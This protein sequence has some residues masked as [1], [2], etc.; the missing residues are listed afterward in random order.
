MLSYI[1]PSSPPLDHLTKSR[2]R[3][4]IHKASKKTKS[5]EPFHVA[6]ANNAPPVKSS[7]LSPPRLKQP[8]TQNNPPRSP[9]SSVNSSV[10]SEQSPDSPTRPQ[11]SP[12]RLTAPED[13]VDI[14]NDWTLVYKPSLR[15]NTA[16]QVWYG[17]GPLGLPVSASSLR[18]YGR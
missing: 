13:N 17:I 8:S 16:N 11:E 6:Y 12:I 3:I 1:S 10:S 5:V 2:P 18:F 4:S 14:E 15:D 9:N 7:N